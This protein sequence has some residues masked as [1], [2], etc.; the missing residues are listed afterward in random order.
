MNEL[1][2]II[3]SLAA[4]NHSDL[5]EGSKKK[6]DPPEREAPVERTRRT[7]VRTYDTGTYSGAYN[8]NNPPK[9][10]PSERMGYINHTS[11]STPIPKR[12][13]FSMFS[14]SDEHLEEMFNMPIKRSWD[15]QQWLE[16]IGFPSDLHPKLDGATYSYAERAFLKLKKAA[17]QR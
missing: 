7:E 11:A 9:V 10:F 13:A 17:H 4:K 5:L 2:S 1:D 16:V 15:F 3:K 12:H 8:P 6:P 14:L